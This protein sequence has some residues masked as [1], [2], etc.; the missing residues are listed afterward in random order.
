ME[1]MTKEIAEIL[2]KLYS[3]EDIDDPIC[4]LKYFTPDSSFSW[5]IFEGEKQVDGDWLFF[6]KVV[7]SLCPEGEL[8]YVRLSELQSVKGPL[9]LGIERDLYWTVKPISQ[10]K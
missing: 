7:S 2:P 4:S 1:L 10:C 8:G 9:G 3:Q 6:S 5:F